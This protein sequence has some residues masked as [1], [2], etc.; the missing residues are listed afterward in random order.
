MKMIME[1]RPGYKLIKTFP[2]GEEVVS[3]LTV[4]GKLVV[5][6]NKHV[7]YQIGDLDNIDRDGLQF[8]YAVFEVWE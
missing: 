8:E 4:K 7:Y 6:T 3:M 1:A 5:A 2:E